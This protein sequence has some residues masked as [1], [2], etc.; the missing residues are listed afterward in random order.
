MISKLALINFI[1]FC[2]D[3]C[4]CIH[5]FSARESNE[6]VESATFGVSSRYDEFPF[7]TAFGW[8]NNETGEIEFLCGGMLIE[9]NFVLTAAH[10]VLFEGKLPDL[11]KIGGNKLNSTYNEDHTVREYFIHHGYDGTES[12]DDVALVQLVRPSS[13]SPICLWNKSTLTTSKVQAIG[14]GATKFAGST[15]PVLQKIN[16]IIVSQKF[17][18][19]Y[20]DRKRKFPFGLSDEH[21]CAGDPAG[22]QDI[23]QGD[24]GGP[25]LIRTDYEIYA[26][27]IISNGQACFGFPPAVYTKT[28]TYINWIDNILQEYGNSRL[29]L[30]D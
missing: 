17:C 10:C 15:T 18:K 30:C 16:L 6:H 27:G 25:L 1:L 26:I 19:A 14:Y 8:H 5:L 21:L 24:S 9:P 23:C 11:I 29:Q 3:Y 12:Y 2:S 28:S 4:L 7:M 20:H 22:Q 13:K